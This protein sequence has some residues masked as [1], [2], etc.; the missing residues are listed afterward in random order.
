MTA[1][2]PKGPKPY[3]E[4]VQTVHSFPVLIHN[5]ILLYFFFKSFSI[6]INRTLGLLKK[7]QWFANFII[8]EKNLTIKFLLF[9]FSRNKGKDSE[10]ENVDSDMEH[11]EPS[12]MVLGST[13][14][15]A[16]SSSHRQLRCTES[17]QKEIDDFEEE[18]RKILSQ[19]SQVRLI[20]SLF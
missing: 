11:M 17:E 9:F 14:S 20:Y 2:E 12:A 1:S 7:S 19:D 15:P 16:T 8:N 4:N 3:F 10:Y 6:C 18:E 5:A 13:T